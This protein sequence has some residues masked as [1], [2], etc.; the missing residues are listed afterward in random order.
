[1]GAVTLL[2]RD[3]SPLVTFVYSYR[4][5]VSFLGEVE[6]ICEALEPAVAWGP[7]APTL[8]SY[9]DV[10]GLRRGQSSIQW[11]GVGTWLAFG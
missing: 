4:Y 11:S 5:I 3:Q 6:V 1:L 2:H 9:F 8:D 7:T 10:L